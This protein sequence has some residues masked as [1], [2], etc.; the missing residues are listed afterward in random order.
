MRCRLLTPE[1]QQAAAPEWLMKFEVPA[2]RCP[3]D[4]AY[5]LG[6]SGETEK[7]LGTEAT[8]DADRDFHHN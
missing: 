7:I 6:H 5:G 4:P 1:E 2:R 3:F 8:G